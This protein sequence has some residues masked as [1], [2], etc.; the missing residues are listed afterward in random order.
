[1]GGYTVIGIPF[2]C[3]VISGLVDETCAGA[4]KLAVAISG[5][6]IAGYCPWRPLSL[7]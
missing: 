5:N 3:D 1:V 2:R 7:A 6:G 4:S